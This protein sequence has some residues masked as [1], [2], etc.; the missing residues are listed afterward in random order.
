MRFSF[1]RIRCF[2]R[3]K[4]NRLSRRQEVILARRVIVL[5]LILALAVFTTVSLYN[6]AAPIAAE[7]A[8]TVVKSRMESLIQK[9]VQKVITEGD[10]HYESFASPTTDSEGKILSIA[11][12]SIGL[13]I[14]RTTLLQELNDAMLKNPAFRIKVPVGSLIAPKFIGGRGF[15]IGINAMT[16][17][18]FR[19]EVI[20]RISSAGINQTLHTLSV[21]V[22]ADTTLYCMNEKNTLDLT[23]EIT[24]AESL[25][26][27]NIPDSYFEYGGITPS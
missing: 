4:R 12:D 27:G 9:T 10:Y 19:A 7:N 14:L 18:A 23:C 1:P 16:Y 6:K 24:L 21:R 22:T 13:A 11:V 20:S 26:F 2:I 5:V 15:S 25:T 8:V 3:R 17:T